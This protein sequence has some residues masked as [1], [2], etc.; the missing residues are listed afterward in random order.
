M[1]MT[2]EERLDHAREALTAYFAAK[3]EP[4]RNTDTDF[5][6]TDTSDL[7]ADL[8]HL[9]KFLGFKDEDSTV[10]TA[11][12]HYDAEQEEEQINTRGRSR[13]KSGSRSRTRRERPFFMRS[14][15]RR[16]P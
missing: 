15:S 2:M 1:P 5:E 14:L 16:K 13:K 8:L 9:Q 4:P 12:M 6:E 10:A 11:L 3:A 7:I